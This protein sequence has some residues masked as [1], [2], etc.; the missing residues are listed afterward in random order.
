MNT[1]NKEI[2]HEDQDVSSYRD[3]VALQFSLGQPGALDL[4]FMQAELDK[5]LAEPLTIDSDSV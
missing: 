5:H 4:A 3:L 2:E 1:S